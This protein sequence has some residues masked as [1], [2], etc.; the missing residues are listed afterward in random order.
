M[1]LLIKDFSAL[2][3]DGSAPRFKMGQVVRLLGTPGVDNDIINEAVKFIFIRGNET[4]LADFQAAEKR[5]M[6]EIENYKKYHK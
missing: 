2:V 5:L 3:S 6:D 1:E 4:P